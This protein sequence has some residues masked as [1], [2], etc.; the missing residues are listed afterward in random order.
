MNS[1]NKKKLLKF[2]YVDDLINFIEDAITNN[3][4]NNSGKRIK[5][6]RSSILNIFKLLCKLN[7]DYS[8]SIRN[9][10]ENKLYVTLKWYKE[11]L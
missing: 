2:T 9:N 10:F 4:I 1:I 7:N 11:N 6:H 3:K 5:Y 8:K